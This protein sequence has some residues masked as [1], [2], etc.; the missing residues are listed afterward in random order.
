MN[1]TRKIRDSRGAPWTSAPVA[2]SASIV[3]AGLMLAA[4]GA[5]TIV[6]PSRDF[7][8]PTDMAFGCL[9]VFKASTGERTLSGQPMDRCHPPGEQDPHPGTTDASG[10]QYRTYGY[11]TNASRGDLSLID[12][13]YCR[14][15]DSTCFPA[16]ADLVDLDPETAGFTAAPVGEVPEV[17]ASSQDGCRVVT[18]N[19]G[20]CDLTMVDPSILLARIWSATATAPENAALTTVTP[21]TGSGRLLNLAPGEIAFLP[22][23]TVN[24]GGN[25]LLCTASGTLAAPVGAPAASVDQR[26]SWRAVVTFP[27][28][29]LVALIDLPSGD[30][31]DSYQVGATG[32]GSFVYSHSGTE[33][34]CAR[35]DCGA[36][37][38]PACS[39]PVNGVGGAGGQGGA[40]PTGTSLGGQAGAATA[41]AGGAGVAGAGGGAGAGDAG[42]AAGAGGEGGDSPGAAGQAGVAGQAGS[43]AAGA[44]GSAA[45]SL[46][47]AQAVLAPGACPGL[48]VG[49]I[50][51]RPEGNRV[52]F[53]AANSVFVGALD[54]VGGAGLAEPAAGE[55][56][57]VHQAGGVLR[58]RLSV[59]PFDYVAGYDRTAP[60]PTA[61]QYGRFVSAINPDVPFQFLYVVAR[62]ATL[63]VIDVSV[64]QPT[65]CDLAI[66][67]TDPKA[68]ALV[69]RH[70]TPPATVTE[71]VPPPIACYP[72][73][74]PNGPRRLPYWAGTDPH[75]ASGPGLHFPSPPVDVAVANLLTS[76][77]EDLTST[78]PLTVQV[79]ETVL[80]GAYAFVLT[81]AGPV[82]VLNIDPVLRR[83]AE[84]VRP[85]V[86]G[87]ARV[88]GRVTES[89]RPLVNSLRDTGVITYSTSLGT[90][91]G[92]PRLD[93][94]PLQASQ[95]PRLREFQPASLDV[96]TTDSDVNARAVPVVDTNGDVEDSAVELSTYV[97]FPNRFL[98][99]PQTWAVTWEG[100]VAGLSYSG[101]LQTTASP[102]SFVLQ[103]Q[104]A[105][106]CGAGVL[107]GDVVTLAGCNQD[108][109][110]PTRVCV[111][112]ETTPSTVDGRSIDG[113]CLPPETATARRD[114]P[115]RD[116]L[117]SFRR[118]EVV[119]S[120]SSVLTLHTK[121]DEF[122]RPTH[123][124]ATGAIVACEAD[125]DCS[126]VAESRVGYKCRATEPV[127]GTPIKRCVHPCTADKDCSPGAHCHAFDIVDP[128]DPPTYCAEGA[129]LTTDI[130]QVCLDQLVTYGVTAGN[131]F[132]VTG[133]VAGRP[134]VVTQRQSD[135][136]CTVAENAASSLRISR[137]PMTVPACQDPPSLPPNGWTDLDLARANPPS[138]NPC[139]VTTTTT[140]GSLAQTE[141]DVWFQN[142]ELRFVLT[143]IDQPFPN[144]VQMSFDVHGGIAPMQVVTLLDATPTLP[145]RLLIG[146]VSALEQLGPA[147]MDNPPAE[148][149]DPS[150]PGAMLSFPASKLPYLYVVDQREYAAGRLIGRG[151]VLRLHPRVASLTPGFEG[152]SLSNHYFPI[153]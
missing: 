100:T 45:D 10:V 118:Y 102:T 111:H 8:R 151:Q 68:G 116:L 63:R 26:A 128:T 64:P 105:P 127:A 23:Q 88:R 1:M 75:I 119:T 12:L 69:T 81:A 35:S 145:A 82:Y 28:C 44:A 70:A 18:A 11:V 60:D 94:E 21:H 61:A 32:T 87:E 73:L 141:T 136:A 115:C 46:A 6:L 40:G 137:I 39:D 30:I 99:R 130:E 84:F 25:S 144:T 50:A 109:D 117:S 20:S 77:Y 57:E 76:E 93:S 139:V 104:G 42:G 110:C 41:G 91:A 80:N 72:Y 98:V 85:D 146:P 29:D 135:Q 36:G 13:S 142:Q 62:D 90:F 134:D 16:G 71:S 58:L 27:S 101:I 112:S 150:N 56:T 37:A 132:V 123:V 53:G 89:P 67:P 97:Y 65:E 66:D 9:G 52:Y 95:G 106:F 43:A 3:L 49:P 121:L 2:A 113:L 54:L 48:R 4:C 108:S 31:L 103:D 147:G 140:Q 133:S 51:V 152:V 7:D 78:T 153:Q 83:T 107:P 149:T 22:Q 122:P 33:P 15:D 74:A 138:P 124:D 14:P 92:P 34:V 96:N 17:V 120:N 19:R 55:N 126:L 24:T 59:D 131:T 143:G 5:Q 125:S 129:D 38:T 79:N 86:P 114:G 47:T 148:I